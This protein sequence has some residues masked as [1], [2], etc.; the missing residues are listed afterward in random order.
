MSIP[1]GIQGG[2]PAASYFLYIHI[3]SELIFGHRCISILLQMGRENIIHGGIAQF[4]TVRT[5]LG[6]QAQ[7]GTNWH[8]ERTVVFPGHVVKNW[9]CCRKSRMAGHLILAVH[10]LLL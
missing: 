10:A 3:K 1:S 6:H 5:N 8:P 9:D 7:N 4:V 2:A